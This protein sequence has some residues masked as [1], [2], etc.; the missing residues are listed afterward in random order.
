MMYANGKGVG[1]IARFSMTAGP[2]LLAGVVATL[3]LNLQNLHVSLL[4]PVYY[5]SGSM[6]ILKGSLTNASFLGESIL[7]MM[8]TPFLAKPET[9]RKPVLLAIGLPSLLA[10]ATAAMAAAMAVATF[11]VEIAS[12]VY[13]PYSSMVR[14]NEPQ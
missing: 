4:L 13:F 2:L 12:S 11:G 6:P 14:F 3:L 5:D 9:A 1:A 10:I 7:I 8:L